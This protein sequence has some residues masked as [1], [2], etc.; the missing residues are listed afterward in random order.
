[1]AG[2]QFQN[3][4]ILL[5]EECECFL[6]FLMN[7]IH[8]FALPNEALICW[9]WLETWARWHEVKIAFSSLK[10]ILTE[11]KRK[12]WK[13]KKSSLRTKRYILMGDTYS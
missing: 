4:M 3:N 7:A 13:K 2:K 12:Y 1:M 9:Q 10:S 6:V 11:Y 5:K 8:S